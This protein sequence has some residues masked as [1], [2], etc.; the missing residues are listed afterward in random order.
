M[1]QDEKLQDEQERNE[2][3][4]KEEELKR[5]QEEKKRLQEEKARL[6]QQEKERLEQELI[7]HERL[8][9]QLQNKASQANNQNNPPNPPTNAP[10]QKPSSP[11]P[12]SFI[13]P[14]SKSSLNIN[15]NLDSNEN[16]EKKEEEVLSQ[17][18]L[19]QND[20]FKIE[21]EMDGKEKKEEP[22]EISKKKNL[23]APLIFDKKQKQKINQIVLE[24]VPKTKETLFSF[25]IDW[26][27]V[28]SND[29]IESKLKPWISN[30]IK[31]LLGEEQPTLV[32]FVL[33]L[34]Q[35]RKTPD[36]IIESPLSEVLE[37]EIDSF[38]FKLW[39][40]FV[41]EIL[42]VKTI[43]GELHIK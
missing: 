19:Q 40:L 15:F 26:P 35:E 7:R 43:L 10:T 24:K 30:I 33:Q 28:E 25:E 22:E 36:Q 5:Q 11:P 39:R 38:V 23:V 6:I 41:F 17:G 16:L 12:E 3:L 21:E 32:E 4:K 2:I 13:L 34:I 37:S 18:G 27:I 8:K 14:D 29:I 1:R 31:E 20:F 9:Q 42:S